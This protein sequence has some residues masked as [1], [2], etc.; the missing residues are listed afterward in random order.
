MVSSFSD[1]DKDGFGDIYGITKKLDYLENLGVKALW[2]T[3]IQLSDSY[4]GYD[5]TDYETVDPKFGSKVSDAAIAN[6]GEVTTAT[7]LAD[8]KQL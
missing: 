8:Y 7:A 5:I 3:P 6:G 4:H 1:S 2:L